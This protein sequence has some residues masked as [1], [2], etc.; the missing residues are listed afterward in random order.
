MASE[1]ILVI[2]NEDS[3][4]ENILELLEA[5]GFTGVGASNGKEGIALVEQHDPALILCD[6]LMPSMS[7]YEVLRAVRRKHRFEQVPFIFL[8]AKVSEADAARGLQAGASHYVTKPF[9]LE[10]LLQVIQ[11]CLRQPRQP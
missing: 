4:R 8:S 5:E 10:E 3:V 7:G 9:S 2:E 11:A 6:V 1:T